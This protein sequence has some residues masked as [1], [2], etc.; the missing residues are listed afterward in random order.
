METG[1]RIATVIVDDNKEA[2]FTLQGF[3]ELMPEIE[4]IGTATNSAKAMKLITERSPDLV[5]LD[6]EMPGKTGFEL[7]NELDK[8]GHQRHF[9]VIFHTAYDK[10]TLKALRE[11]AFD[12]ILKPPCEED[13]KT[14]IQ[15]VL[16][17]RSKPWH[18]H[19]LAYAKP[20]HQMVALPTN[21]GMQ[22]VSKADIVLLECR[23]EA[24]GMR[25]V[26]YAILNN[27]Q[28]I[29]LGQGTNAAAILKYLG[30]EH[31]VSLSQSVIVNVS[32][33]MM[34][35]YKTCICSLYPPFDHTKYKVSRQC[36]SKLR[37]RFD[38]I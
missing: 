26:W 28:S 16:D 31:F 13:L 7:L 37:E 15:R 23:K 38:M 19:S 22:F 24:I 12:F 14:A 35:E 20:M 5:F 25:S 2:I 3:L 33:M 17:Q 1:K 34:I 27:H 18:Q 32:F 30:S 11:S 21:T 6:V 29:R 36:M 10:Y 9:K 8:A 4:I